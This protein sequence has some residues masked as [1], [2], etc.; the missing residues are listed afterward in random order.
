MRVPP[1]NG[2][3]PDFLV[4]PSD[5]QHLPVRQL[6]VNYWS[7]CSSSQVGKFQGDSI[8]GPE[9]IAYVTPDEKITDDYTVS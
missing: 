7:Q 4:P 9:G 3:D 6:F 2:F 5:G 8:T 1:R